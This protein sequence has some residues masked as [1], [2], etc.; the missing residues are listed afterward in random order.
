MDNIGFQD[1]SS[2]VDFTNLIDLAKIN[3]LKVDFFS[4]QRKFLLEFGI[5]QR[6]EKILLNITNEESKIIKSGVDRLINK[7]G[8]GTLFKVLVVSK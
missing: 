6:L 3:N 7:D 8:M 5:K 4:S 2:L 1:I